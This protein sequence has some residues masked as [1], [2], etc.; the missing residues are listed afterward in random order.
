MARPLDSEYADYYR[1]YTS[2][3]P[4]GNVLETLRRQHEETQE[5]L[6]GLDN[7][8][9]EHRYAPGKWSIK[10]VVGHLVDT[11]RIFAH[12]ALTFARQDRS[13]LPGMDQDEYV[14]HGKFDQRSLEDLMAEWKSLRQAN[15]HLFASFDEE[16]AQRTGEASGY[17]FSVRSLVYIVAGHEIHHVGVLR[18]RYL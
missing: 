9:A 6:A 3:V 7:S 10:E 15:L 4:E 13:P 18:D 14:A 17:S 2:K 5:L 8:Q 12:R 1:T 11:E 16:V